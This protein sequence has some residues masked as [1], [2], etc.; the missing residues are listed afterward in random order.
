MSKTKTPGAPLTI[1]WKDYALTIRGSALPRG[2]TKVH[3]TYLEAV[4]RA[5]STKR[6]WGETCIYHYSEVRAATDTRIELRSF[7]DGGV[8]IDHVLTAGQDEIDFRLTASN[9]T[10]VASD[11][12]W[13][14]A[15]I[16]VP[17]FTGT[18]G[19]E[20]RSDYLGKCF[21][22]LDGKLS[23]LPVRPWATEALYTPGQTWCP[24][25]VSRDDVNPR[26][27]SDLV[28]SN[29]LIGC[30]SGDESTILATAWQPYQELFQGVITC[31]HSDVRIGGLA[32]GESKTMRGKIYVVTADAEA[33][34]ARYE[35][36]FPEHR[37]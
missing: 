16:Q 19:D 33:L 12:A 11:A 23:R 10:A 18:V 36:D 8:I 1:E 3:V 31:I 6:N 9:P 35:K 32:P 17:E 21:I 37:G 24:R 20:T 22:F 29:G 14:Q 13:G 34:V 15:C 30:F 28:P 26:P 4:C 2:C 25:H 5:G 7:V 27:L